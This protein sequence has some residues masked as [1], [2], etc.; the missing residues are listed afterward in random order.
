M[1]G[2]EGDKNDISD[3]MSIWKKFHINGGP[4]PAAQ[5]VRNKAGTRMGAERGR[6]RNRSLR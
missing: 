5:C 4:E 3:N 2:I 6:D 1:L